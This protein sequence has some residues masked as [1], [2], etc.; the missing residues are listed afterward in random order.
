MIYFCDAAGSAL[1]CV[2]ERVYQGS[3]E[4]SFVT[5][6][7]PF[8]E[9]AQMSVGF[10]LPNGE[11]SEKYY[12]RYA[13]MLDG[14]QTKKGE[15]LCSWRASLPA[16]VTS[17][18]GRVTAQFYQTGS[19]GE[20]I[21]TSPVQFTVE[22]GADCELPAMPVQN[23]YE[24]IL[25]VIAQICADVQN[26]AYAA[27]AIYA[28][29]SEYTYGANEITL[30]PDANGNGTFVKSLAENNTA[31][32]YGATGE[33]NAQYWEEV[34]RFDELMNK[35]EEAVEAAEIATAAADVAT[36]KSQAAVQAAAQAQESALS[37]AES[38]AA[39]ESALENAEAVVG[40]DFVLN[41]QWQKILDGTQQVGAAL[42]AE[43]AQKDGAGNVIAS[44]YAT[45]AA[46]NSKYSK[47]SGGIPQTDLAQSVQDVLGSAG[48]LKIPNFGTMTEFGTVNVE[49]TVDENV[50]FV[51]ATINGNTVLFSKVCSFTSPYVADI[52]H[53]FST[54]GVMDADTFMD[55]VWERYL[56][57]YIPSM[58]AATMIPLRFNGYVPN[59]YNGFN[60]RI[61][62]VTEDG[63]G[64]EWKAFPIASA[65][66]VG[67]V[68][69]AT[70]TTGMTQEVG[71]DSA[72]KLWVAPNA[73]QSSVLELTN[74]DVSNADG[75]A[76]VSFSG[77][78]PMAKVMTARLAIELASD[79][80]PT[81]TRY[82]GFTVPPINDLVDEPVYV[83]FMDE[84]GVSHR[85][86]FTQTSG[87]L[88]LTIVPGLTVEEGKE[89][90]DAV[91][92]IYT[93]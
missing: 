14:F 82:Y 31:A 81:L 15:R 29:N 18:Y 4:A 72:G 76:T 55:E 38:A 69:A 61:L 32:P 7:A 39:A 46:M 65:S 45:I 25:A 85:A 11:K 10:R 53:G 60:N 3:S 54:V 48:M 77:T 88:T 57:A 44:T 62:S 74:A 36:E 42:T 16:S 13:G 78:L 70:K 24:Q 59:V 66:A 67:G 41:T 58:N 26:A 9:S 68:K 28:W 8:S 84:S 56:I 47:P 51:Q 79:G 91:L 83:S 73:S 87:S 75:Q 5:L 92:R 49:Q 22:R 80:I 50:Q 21:A 20:I 64:Y 63:E 90:W 89:I 1:R 17:H 40:H 33:L 37:A 27:R 34:C 12:M 43:Q 2:P 86:H 30:C 6:V 23:I 52:F 35:G 19:S 93:D 71:V